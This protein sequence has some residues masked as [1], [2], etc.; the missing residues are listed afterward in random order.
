MIYLAFVSNFRTMLA[1]TTFNGRPVCPS[2]C[3]PHLK[4]F[5]VKNS[6]SVY[7]RVNVTRKCFPVDGRFNC[8]LIF[9]LTTPIPLRIAIVN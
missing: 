2:Y 8:I 1:K 3:T 6:L 5:Q 7:I 4:Q 9:R